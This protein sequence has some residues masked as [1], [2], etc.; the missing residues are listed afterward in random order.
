[1]IRRGVNAY[2]VF[3]GKHIKSKI[4]SAI[5]MDNFHVIY[6]NIQYLNIIILLL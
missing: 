2:R 5:T 1:M 3:S 4:D 6:Y